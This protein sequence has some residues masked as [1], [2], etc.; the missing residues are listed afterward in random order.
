VLSEARAGRPLVALAVRDAAQV[1]WSVL[2]QTLQINR[3]TLIRTAITPRTFRIMVE[4]RRSS[5]RRATRHAALSSNSR[6]VLYLFRQT[7][8]LSETSCFIGDLENDTSRC[9]ECL[10]AQNSLLAAALDSG[11]LSTTRLITCR[12]FASPSPAAV[13]STFSEQ[14]ATRRAKDMSWRCRRR[15]HG[16]I[17][18]SHGEPTMDFRV[19]VWTGHRILTLFEEMGH[20]AL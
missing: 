15:W 5:L 12:L 10:I 14:W 8:F 17:Y 2:Q 11:G 9:A 16:S 19:L 4:A 20:G 18:C 3:A 7:P 13:P 1:H 6:V